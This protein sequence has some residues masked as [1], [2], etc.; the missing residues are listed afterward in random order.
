MI[1]PLDAPRLQ[2]DRGGE[3]PFIA[4]RDRKL[5]YAE[6][7][8][9][10]ARLSRTLKQ[11]GVGRG[12]HVTILMSN[13]PDYAVALFGVW[14][15]DGV[16]VMVNAQTQPK[17]LAWILR[18]S[19]SVALISE[20]NLER[21]YAPAVVESG[22]SMVLAIT[23]GSEDFEV[24][25]ETAPI[26][27]R[28]R[29]PQVPG[30]AAILYTSGTTGDPKGVMHTHASLGFTRDSV[31]EYLGLNENDRMF[32]ALPLS[33]GYGLFQLLPAT[34]VGA[35]VILERNFTYPAH[36]FPRM[37]SEKI[38][39][40]AG[41]PTVFAMMLAHEAKY[42]LSFP[43]VRIVTNAAAPLPPAFVPGI[44]RL[45]PAASLVNMYGQTECIRASYLPPHLVEKHPDS[46]GVAI[47]GTELLVL[48]D[49]GLEAN[50]GEIGTL[51][52]RGPNIM[53]GYWKNPE[54]TAE[55]LVPGPAPGEVILR[56]GDRFRRDSEGLHYFV[57]R[58]DDIIKSRGEKVSPAEV[59]NAIHSLPDVA[60]AI[61]LGVPDP[62]LG[63]AIL[64]LVTLKPDR[65]LH[66]NQ[67]KRACGEQLEPFMVP[68]HVIF[69]DTLPRTP[70][71]KLSRKLVFEHFRAQLLVPFPMP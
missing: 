47:P 10:V 14:L 11:G 25:A 19:E 49:D 12:D 46:V 42:S 30:L 5:S 58:E 39:T 23:E 37:L 2:A 62:L 59:E 18:D 48:D 57:G 29:D 43:S 4:A 35:T 60:E 44:R 15:A 32:C 64:A 27:S 24:V 26:V 13:V 8:S 6:L 9:R 40:F 52:I 20:L 53:R 45:F 21:A 16:A 28:S 63:Q 50:A 65:K 1:L 33:F 22:V 61:V 67:V 38:T 71:G 34:A 17:K 7:W 56:T 66:E 3:R 51:H 55:V 68:R 69:V 41:V 31:V 70:N 36:L 54:Q